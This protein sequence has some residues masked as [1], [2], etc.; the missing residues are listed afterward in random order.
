M[1]AATHLSSKT[2]LPSQLRT[3]EWDTLTAA[4]PTLAAWVNER[5]FFMAS[6]TQ[7]ATLQDFR[8][9]A[10]AITAGKIGPQEARRILRAQLAAAGYQ[11]HP[12]L[13]GTI[14]DL[15]STARLKVTLETNLAQARGW[16]QHQ[17]AMQNTTRPG[18]R[19]FRAGHAAAPRDWTTRWQ[20]AYAQ[21]TP[22]EQQYA[23]PGNNPADLCALKISRIWTLL[24]RFGTPYP[25]FDFNSHMRLKSLTRQ[26]CTTL[27]ILPLDPAEQA[28][29]A[30]TQRQN[31]SS[32]N[33]NTAAALP[34]L[35]PDLRTQLTAT[36]RG[37]A[38]LNGDT[39][40]MV[41]QNGT[42]PYT[43]QQ[44][45]PIISAPNPAAP[46]LQLLAFKDWATDPTRFSRNS[47]DPAPLDEV[48]DLTRLLTRITPTPSAP[49]TPTLRHIIPASDADHLRTLLNTLT[50]TGTYTPPQDNPAQL[51][52]HT[53]TTNPHAYSII[54]ICRNYHTPI[55]PDTL[56]QA[57][58]ASTPGYLFTPTARFRI[59]RTLA[60]TSN[61]HRGTTISIEVEEL[62][63]PSTPI[64]N[65]LT[66]N[67]NS[68]R[69]IR[70]TSDGRFAKKGQG[71]ILQAKE[72]DHNAPTD[73]SKEKE[74]TDSNP[75]ASSSSGKKPA[76]TRVPSEA[77]L[78]S[79]ERR[80]IDTIISYNEADEIFN[81]YQ[82]EHENGIKLQI[83]KL[84][85]TLLPKDEKG[86]YS[87]VIL[88][89]SI[90]GAEEALF[91]SNSIKEMMN[92]K[93]LI[94]SITH[95]ASIETHIQAI[96]KTPELIQQAKLI[97]TGDGGKKDRVRYTKE[98]KAV[99]QKDEVEYTPIAEASFRASDGEMYTVRY[100]IYKYRMKNMTPKIHYLYC[101][102]S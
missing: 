46:Q 7:A 96:L 60:T 64:T 32:L 16:A 6:V 21:L 102:K 13:T 70:R 20:Q 73:T 93:A 28:T 17:T 50:A 53:R 35:D 67:N 100:T 14:K 82:K 45:G 52:H 94:S 29:I 98:G 37:I 25:P 74:E 87:P 47:E 101:R 39:L 69:E 18:F 51:W 95:G 83:G 71:S 3:A 92:R 5:A 59:I 89:T 55:R 88:K 19:L 91:G 26:E 27:G 8:D 90:P 72:K 76:G 31:Y 86:N 12:S 34:T 78:E 48:E 63:P 38:T 10:A 42:K 84:K 11:A 79:A 22:Q 61:Q 24:S 99:I 40:T 41:D 81:S 23:T 58:S 9:T 15:T 44:I 77:Y 62:P 43:W 33:Q 65:R 1:P 97:E 2:L 80:K 85:D 4:N 57:I 56:Y 30:A 68:E 49:G 54:L 75:E 36:L 66:T